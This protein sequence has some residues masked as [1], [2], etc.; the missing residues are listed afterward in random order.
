MMR[1]IKTYSQGAELYPIHG[2]VRFR[3]PWSRY[4]DALIAWGGVAAQAVVA[5]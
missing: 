5:V 4:D 3:Q 2:C 1:T